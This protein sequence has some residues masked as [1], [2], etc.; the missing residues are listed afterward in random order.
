MKVTCATIVEDSEGRVLIGHATNQT[1]WS[2]P[3]GCIDPGETPEEC[4]RRELK[5]ETD[6]Q[7]TSTPFEDLGEH[8]YI[9]GKKLHLFRVPYFHLV[10]YQHLIM[11]NSIFEYNGQLVPEFDA[12]VVA[13]WNAIKHILFKPQVEILR[14]FY[15]K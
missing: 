15:D 14:K 9:A 6:L 3:K 13:D 1:I 12:F 7:F 2:L 10:E 8:P 4:A 11:C 5:E